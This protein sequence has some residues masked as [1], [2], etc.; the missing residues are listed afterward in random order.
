M[1]VK[2]FC[3]LFM[4]SMFGVGLRLCSQTL[5]QVGDSEFEIISRQW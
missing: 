4:Q 1:Y 2:R 5:Q 3:F